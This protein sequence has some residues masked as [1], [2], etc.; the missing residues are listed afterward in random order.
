DDI[1]RSREDQAVFFRHALLRL[2][3]GGRK[4]DIE[5]EL[6]GRGAPPQVAKFI[7]RQARRVI[8]S[9][10]RKVGFQN[11]GLGLGLF[12]LGTV[13]TLISLTFARHIGV[14]VI[15]GGLTVSGVVVFFRGLFQFVTGSDV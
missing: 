6:V 12:L 13:I 7:L 5:A 1:Q 2:T 15:M 4:S 14:W 3:S 8:R 10:V 9:E 11:L